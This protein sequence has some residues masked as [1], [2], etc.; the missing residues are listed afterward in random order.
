MM[1]ISVIGLGKLGLPLAAHLA[2]LGHNVRGY[3]K[4]PDRRDVVQA[5]L[6]GAGPCPV[7][8]PGV[9]RLRGFELS[10]VAEAGDVTMIVVPTPST[11]TGSFANSFVLTA[12]HDIAPSLRLRC[13]EGKQMPVV[14]L[15]STVSPGSCRDVILPALASAT[16]GSNG[17]DF[18][19]VYN[20]EFIALG[21]ILNDLRSPDFILAGALP[22]RVGCV[23]D[24][25]DEIYGP[26]Q[27]LRKGNYLSYHKR[28]MDYTSAE[29]AKLALNCYVTQKICF[30]NAVGE[31][32]ERA[33]A[34]TDHVLHAVG[35]D[36]RV[37][38]RYL[39]AGA[40][41]GGPCFP[42]DGHALQAALRLVRAPQPIQNFLGGP[43]LYR[44]WQLEEQAKAIR[45]SIPARSK[46]VVCG[47]SYKQGHTLEEESAGR[48]LCHDLEHAGHSVLVADSGAHALSLAGDADALAVMLPGLCY[49]WSA[50]VGRLG[51]GALVWAPWG[52]PPMSVCDAAPVYYSRG[53]VP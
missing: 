39:R 40:P 26:G 47:V 24:L 37:G 22:E 46:V 28:V 16:G 21:S 18:D 36:S 6:E 17:V 8:E 11:P 49:D 4:S 32:C 52:D 9:D 2:S 50:I 10:P 19:F 38:Y 7:D 43:V 41:Y 14:V 5:W 27:E 34:N 13:E 20:P 15:V 45:R 53:F 35:M 51:H 25:L 30:A 31:L 3:D 33:G 1:N 44:D 29:I 12:I 48:R 23:M 42:R